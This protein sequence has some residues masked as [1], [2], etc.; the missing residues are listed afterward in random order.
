MSKTVTPA[1]LEAA[2]KQAVVLKVT[3]PDAIA[4]LAK[5]IQFRGE[6]WASE[7]P[8]T[9]K[10][11][12]EGDWRQ[13]SVNLAAS[14]WATN[15]PNDSQEVQDLMRAYA[16]KSGFNASASGSK[17]PTW[18]PSACN[19]VE[20]AREKF[21]KHVKYQE[22]TNMAKDGTNLHVVYADFRGKITV[23]YGH[24]VTPDDKLK[25]GD[26]ISEGRAL[27][28]LH[29]DTAEAWTAAERQARQLKIN[30]LDFTA[31]LAS[32]NYQ[33]GTGWN[34]IHKQTWDLMRQGKFRE[35]AIEAQDSNWNDQT[36]RR[37]EDFRIA[38]TQLANDVQ[39]HK[40]PSAQ[41]TLAIL[42]PGPN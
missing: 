4:V 14:K 26:R 16:R 8:N 31:A 1:N 10:R 15:N 24:Q 33:L 21:I 40:Q 36:P 6:N 3:D 39:N 25:L 5:L 34:T 35:A 38:L 22:G 17:Y 19:S 30:N 11:M 7:F 37:V 27:Q 2:K 23:G 18:C 42:T 41:G 12:K 9:Y 32:V 13:A 20:E 29:E 28:L